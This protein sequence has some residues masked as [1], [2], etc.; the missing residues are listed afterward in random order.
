VAVKTILFLEIFKPVFTFCSH[1]NPLKTP[2]RNF[3]NLKTEDRAAVEHQKIKISK[4]C[5]ECALAALT[6]VFLYRFV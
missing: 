3:K 2:L 4:S 5:F 1:G 6:T